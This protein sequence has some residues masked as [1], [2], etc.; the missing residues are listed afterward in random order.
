M[1]KR[2]KPFYING[3]GAMGEGMDA[4]ADT[5]EEMHKAIDEFLDKG[6][7]VVTLLKGPPGAP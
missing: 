6:C 3:I 2:I 1:M 5:R 7:T 4:V